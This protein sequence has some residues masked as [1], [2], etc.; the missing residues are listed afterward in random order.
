MSEFLFLM[1]LFYK[2]LRLFCDSFIQI[3]TLFVLVKE[4]ER[5]DYSNTRK[6]LL[7]QNGTV[8]PNVDIY[9][10]NGFKSKATVH[11][12]TSTLRNSAIS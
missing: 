6:Y 8:L 10:L 2:I 7:K 12:P 3:F 1:T 11:P 9:Y 4:L 5:D